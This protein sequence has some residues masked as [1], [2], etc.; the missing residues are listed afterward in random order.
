M[1][2]NDGFLSTFK[3]NLQGNFG[4]AY[5]FYVK[6]DSSP[7]VVP[8]SQKFLV[9]SSSMPTHTLEEITVPFQGM[10]FKF[11]STQTFE[12]WECTFNFD[13]GGSLRKSMVDWMN[14]AHNA[15]TNQHGTPDNYYGNI[16]IELLDPFQDFNTGEPNANYVCTLYNAWPSSVGALELDYSN[17]D[18]GQFPCTFTYN[19]HEEEQ[20]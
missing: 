11:A 15:K 4:R 12:T 7:V 13:A 14:I 3:A 1:P 17:K 20:L 2:K 16:V 18:V 6:I 9:R 8:D 10:Q 5:L 19:W